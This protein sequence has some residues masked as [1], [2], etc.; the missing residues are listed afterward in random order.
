MDPEKVWSYETGFKSEWLNHSLRLN[1]TAFYMVYSDMQTETQEGPFVLLTN[2]SQAQIYGLELE[3]AATPAEGFTLN[4]SMSYLHAEYSD[5][6][7]VAD[8]NGTLVDANGNR[9]PRSPEFK[10][11]LGAQYRIPVSNLG[12]ITFRGD[13]SW[14]DD[15][16]FFP[17]ND[18]M[19]NDYSIVHGMV[20]FE[21][22]DG[23]WS[24]E[25]YGK[26]LT[27]A[28]YFSL[29]GPLFGSRDVIAQSTAPRTF[30]IQVSYEY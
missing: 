15:Y 16:Y 14:T 12:F 19:Q 25:A 20:R 2:A 18:Q 21:T 23:H 24:V 9:L 27:K 8:S 1:G 29:I 13:L 5:T 26:N 10:I 17:H 4:G 6:L 11:V 30:G 3:M 28:R 7:I 22:A